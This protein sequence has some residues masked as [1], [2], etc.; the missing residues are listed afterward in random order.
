MICDFYL[1]FLDL[2]CNFIINKFKL[3]V[4][5]FKEEKKENKEGNKD[6]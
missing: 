5:L 2:V 1:Q 6:G 4:E 3:K